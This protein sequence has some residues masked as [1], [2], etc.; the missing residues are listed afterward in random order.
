ME[1]L[2]RLRGRGGEGLKRTRGSSGL[3]AVSLLSVVLASCGKGEV[4]PPQNPPDALLRDSLQ[5]GDDD[6]VFRISLS[7]EN[8]DN[9][10]DPTTIQVPMGAWVEFVS[11]DGWPRTVAF[12]LDSLSSPAAELLR[13]SGQDA[14]PPLLDAGDRFVVTFTGAPAGRYPFRIEGSAGP[15]EGAVVIGESEPEDFSATH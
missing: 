9:R 3:T 4:P 6:R 11:V 14:S 12:V 1:V 10:A 15:V 13:S 8:G 7:S 2:H 5:L